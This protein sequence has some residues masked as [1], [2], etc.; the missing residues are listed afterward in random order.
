MQFAYKGRERTLIEM[1]FDKYLLS[2]K[3]AGGFHV[4]LVF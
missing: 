3:T 4:V 1:R 2:L